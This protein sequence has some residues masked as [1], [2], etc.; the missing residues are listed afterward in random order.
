[1]G[2]VP[3]F[4]QVEGK[5]CLV[6]GGGQVAQRKVE[7]LLAAGGSVT[8]IS[9]RVTVALAD[10]ARAGRISLHQRGYR[11]GDMTGYA[12]VYAATDDPELHRR[13]F[14]EAGRRNILINV[15]DKPEFCSFIVPA[16]ARR[17]RV[18]VAIST[19][20]ASPA[21]S[22][23]LRERVEAWLGVGEE[24]EVLLEVNAGAREWLKR[25]ETDAS[26]R[27]RKLNALADSG[28]S[29]ALRLGDAHAVEKILAQCL[30]SEVRLDELGVNPRWFSPAPRRAGG[31]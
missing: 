5:R 17:G 20:G 9:L 8:V 27:A 6:I 25:H 3:I 12:L 16:V 7:T 10:Q 14:A 13:L 19:E 1:M 11:E 2:F 4:L 22:R 21:L 24:M 31:G 26:A 29:D 15:A 30:G 28:L 18:Q 23:H